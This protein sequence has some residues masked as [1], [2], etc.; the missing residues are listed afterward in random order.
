[1]IENIT[2]FTDASFCHDTKAGAGACWSRSDKHRH[3]SVFP[4]PGLLTSNECE[5]AAA[6]EGLRRTIEDPKIAE[7]IASQQCRIILVSDCTGVQR[8]LM[9]DVVT[10]PIAVDIVKQ[11]KS[12]NLFYR[13]NHVKAHTNSTTPRS[14]VNRWCDTRAR[15][16]MRT[17]R[18]NL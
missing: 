6:C 16:L 5:I 17:I 13:V 4:L 3:S 8:A 7:L 11:M 14:W 10:D 2:V 12:L 18:S 15:R 1:M 9:A